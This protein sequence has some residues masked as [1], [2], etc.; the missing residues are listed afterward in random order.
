MKNDKG[1]TLI[2]ILAAITLFGVII[3]VFLSLFSDQ[4]V[5]SNRVENELDAIHVAELAS[6]TVLANSD[7]RQDIRNNAESCKVR[8]EAGIVPLDAI[9]VDSPD[10]ETGPESYVNYTTSGGQAYN[11][12]LKSHCLEDHESELYPVSIEVYRLSGDN[13]QFLT[14]TYRYIKGESAYE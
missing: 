13:Y 9:T 7:I 8:E 12:L 5:L 11:L 3:S 2:E 14:E 6:D 10:Y 1:L 4:L